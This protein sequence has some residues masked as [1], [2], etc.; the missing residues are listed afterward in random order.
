MQVDLAYKSVFEKPVGG[1]DKDDQLFVHGISSFVRAA[2]DGSQKK[3]L[4]KSYLDKIQCI[5]FLSTQRT[6]YT[7]KGIG[8]FYFPPLQIFISIGP[9]KVR[10]V[11]HT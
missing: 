11:P 8:C 7:L 3:Y 4:M 1:G 5:P 10:G 6:M 9:Y 2:Y